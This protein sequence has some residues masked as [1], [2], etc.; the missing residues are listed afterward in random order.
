M[1]EDHKMKNK[2]LITSSLA[3][4][5]LLI[6]ATVSMSFSTE[7][8]SKTVD[9]SIKQSF[10]NYSEIVKLNSKIY[11]LNPTKSV[12]VQKADLIMDANFRTAERI[13][14][15]K[16]VEFSKSLQSE[17]SIA[18]QNLTGSFYGQ[19][20]FA[21]FKTNLAPEVETADANMDAAIID[22]ME[23][24]SKVMSFKMQLLPQL[25]E[26]DAA[27]DNMVSISTIKR[28]SPVVAHE[29]DIM[30]DKLIMNIND[31][32]SDSIEADYLM[33]LLINQ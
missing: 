24:R 3:G 1:I 10:R 13:N 4:L 19:M 15:K 30:M 11:T 29:A 12:S 22:E 18:D 21:D 26:A 16:A 8:T 28:I 25:N 2:K 23:R 20:L 33:D 9:S 27:M 31:L 17:M 7:D 14:R 32:S 6:F 5:A